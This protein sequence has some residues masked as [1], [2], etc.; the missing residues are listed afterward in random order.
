MFRKLKIAL[1][2]AS[3]SMDNPPWWFRDICEPHEP[4]PEEPLDLPDDLSGSYSCLSGTPPEEIAYQHRGKY[5]TDIEKLEWRIAHEYAKKL[6]YKLLERWE[7][8]LE[9]H[10]HY[11]YR[12]RYAKEILRR[13]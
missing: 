13:I 12:V 10:R 1:I 2:A 3:I 4:A 8:E 7:L 6:Y 11:E 9:I 5:V